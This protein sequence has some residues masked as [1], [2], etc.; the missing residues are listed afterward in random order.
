MR[1]VA[2]IDHAEVI[3]KILTHLRLRLRVNNCNDSRRAR[4]PHR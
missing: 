3:E 1:I 2:F 4:S